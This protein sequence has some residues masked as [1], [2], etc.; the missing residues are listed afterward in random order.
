[1]LPNCDYSLPGREKPVGY[2]LN[3]T[4]MPIL[5]SL[6]FNNQY[7]KTIF[8]SKFSSLGGLIE[9]HFSSDIK[10]ISSFTSGY[11]KTHLKPPIT[12]L[13]VDDP[14]HSEYLSQ[15][16][17]AYTDI[18]I[19]AVGFDKSIE[20][21]IDLF[22]LGYNAYLPIDCSLST[23][24]EALTTLNNHSYY[25]P[26]DKVEALLKYLHQHKEDTL[27]NR[28]GTQENELT[29]LTAKEKEVVQLLIIGY[30]YK[31]IAQIIGLTS[32]AVNQRTKKIFKKYGVKNRSELTYQLL[33]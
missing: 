21:I 8:E 5:A 24:I 31:E 2:N 27:L 11:T 4:P 19:I 12:L 6:L 1:M 18:K 16:R 30:S 25:L 33:K 10:D 20:Q 3:Q 13:A 28:I 23:L 17:K 26:T 7:L 9:H 32:F 22:Q 14:L 29:A 15:L